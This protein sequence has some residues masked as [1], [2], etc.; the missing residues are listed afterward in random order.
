[1]VPQLTTKVTR[2][3]DFE[4]PKSANQRICLEDFKIVNHLP[5]Q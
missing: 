3:D 5:C 1:M 2:R 4:I